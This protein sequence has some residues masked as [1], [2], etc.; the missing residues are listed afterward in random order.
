MADPERSQRR[1]VVVVEWLVLW[2]ITQYLDSRNLREWVTPSVILVGTLFLMWRNT[3]W[4][5]ESL[6]IGHRNMSDPFCE[7]SDLSGL[8][9]V[10]FC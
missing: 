7:C 3:A 4:P 5:P 10:Y 6:T 2:A 8:R 1:T 9:P